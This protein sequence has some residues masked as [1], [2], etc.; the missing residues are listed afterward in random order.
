MN[1][2]AANRREENFARIVSE[3]HG[4]VELTSP[5]EMARALCDAVPTELLVYIT[6]QSEQTVQRWA[7]GDVTDMS[8]ESERRL[9]TAYEIMQLIDRFEAP[10]VAATW[11]MGTEPQL[12]FVM[13]AK[14]LRGDQ[15]EEALAA[16]RHFV[17]VG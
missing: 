1:A 11:F 3:V 2:D 12:D 9:A 17:A 10:G 4:L 8:Q 14:A 6:G 15:L 7:S 16:A 5:G 13:P